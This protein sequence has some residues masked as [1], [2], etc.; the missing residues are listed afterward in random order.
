MPRGK[1]SV[2]DVVASL[3]RFDDSAP[4]CLRWL[5]AELQQLLGAEKSLAFTLTAGEA[6]V[7][8]DSL[9]APG[10]RHEDFQR[11]FS[12]LTARHPRGWAAYDAFRPEPEQRNRALSV[13]R[14][15]GRERLES[16]P[17]YQVMTRHGFGRRD[18]LRVLVCEG[19]TLLAWIG[20]LR[21]SP[22][23]PRDVSVLQR[24]VPHVRRRLLLERRIA[25]AGFYRSAMEA[26]LEALPRPAFLLRARGEI[27]TANAPGRLALER[28]KTGPM[29][30]LLR[31][32]ERFERTRLRAVG[33]PEHVLVVQRAKAGPPT[34]EQAQRASAEWE[35]TPR[36]AEVLSW[37]L[38]GATNREIAGALGCA[39]HTVEL[40][41][42]ALL[43][44]SGTATRAELVS[45]AW[46]L[47]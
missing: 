44:A 10:V 2:R 20:V 37:V 19:A 25:E 3:Q 26:A 9:V 45:R 35:V 18:Q 27:V 13:Y 47:R 29:P 36:Q 14:F 21:P 15:L 41:V 1:H 30:C 39:V 12:A 5:G 17:A 16:L 23:T 7:S 4:G 8:L 11:D 40:H 31:G 24:L 34:A 22:F 43:E 28:W 38:Q 42:S 33:Y 32:D 6:T 46:Q